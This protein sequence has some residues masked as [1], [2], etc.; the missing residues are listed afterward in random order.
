[1]V[2]HGKMLRMNAP[3]GPLQGM[4]VTVVWTISLEPNGEGS[5]IVFEEI[6]SGT[7]ES[8]LD[9]LAPAVDGVKSIAI[10][11]LAGDMSDPVEN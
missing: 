7:A 10:Q 1:M 11:R 3:F 6:A 4:G 9:Q 8:G 2:Q 5:T